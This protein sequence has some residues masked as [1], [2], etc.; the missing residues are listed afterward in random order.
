MFALPLGTISMVW[1]IILS[2]HT[3]NA[4]PF[5]MF[6][7]ITTVKIFYLIVA[8]VFVSITLSFRDSNGDFP[9]SYFAIY[10]LYMIGSQLIGSTCFLAI[11]SILSNVADPAI[12]G[13]YMTLLATVVNLGSMYPSTAALY[14]IG[15]FTVKACVPKTT[16]SSSNFTLVFSSFNETVSA[17][18]IQNKCSTPAL[19]EV[20]YFKN[21]LFAENLSFKNGFLFLI[22]NRNARKSRVFA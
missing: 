7:K 1:P 3:A 17:M 22:S 19:S 21:Y 5:M 14:L 15:F 6:F 16:D 4:N 20:F 10:I 12:G 2:K 13:T 11:G 18:M 8:V 9:I